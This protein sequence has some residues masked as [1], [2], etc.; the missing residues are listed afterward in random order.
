[1]S[2]LWNSKKALKSSTRIAPNDAIMVLEDRILMDAEANIS[3]T[4]VPPSI[5][6]G[7]DFTL[8]VVFDNVPDGDP[9][10]TTGFGPYLNI[11]VPVNGRDG[12]DPDDG[13]DGVTLLNATYQG[14][15]LTTQTLTFATDSDGNGQLD[16]SSLWRNYRLVPL[17]QI[18]HQPMF[19]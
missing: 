18:K 1:M 7:G 6:P 17:L 15:R 9:G 16:V 13:P 14:T 12:G 19:Y 11:Y 8:N 10:S 5:S 3:I 2:F 4:G